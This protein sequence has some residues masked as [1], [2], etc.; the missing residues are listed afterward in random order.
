[1]VALATFIPVPL[2]N[3]VAPELTVAVAVAAP[4]EALFKIFKIP[5][6][7]LVLP[8]KVLA[9]GKVSMPTPALLIVPLPLMT[10]DKVSAPAI[11]L[12]ILIVLVP[13]MA[14]L[15]LMLLVPLALSDYWSGAGPS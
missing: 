4:S 10:P 11:G 2:N 6:L 9:L 7:T 13:L 15:P 5:L 8:V 3:N 12:A 1:M 14:M